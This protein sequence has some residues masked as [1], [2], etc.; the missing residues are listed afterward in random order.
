MAE[1]K[2]NRSKALM[3]QAQ[4]SYRDFSFY[5][6]WGKKSHWQMDAPTPHAWLMGQLKGV[7]EVEAFSD[8]EQTILHLEKLPHIPSADSWP[9]DRR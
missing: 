1:A 8:Y 5:S 6:K 7:K 2:H 4:W 9:W 3:W